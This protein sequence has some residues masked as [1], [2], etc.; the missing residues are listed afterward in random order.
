MRD[1]ERRIPVAVA[2]ICGR[3]GRETAA[4][5]LED[6]AF[7]LVLGLERPGHSMA[8]R[9]L[10][11]ESTE[12][13]GLRGRIK[14]VASESPDLSE[15]RVFV[16]FSTAEGSAHHAEMCASAGT[17]AVIGVT[18][19]SEEQMQT[20]KKASEKVA[21][22]YSPNMSTGV[23]L[24]AR[25]VAEAARR[26]PVAYDIE[27]VE[28]HHRGK[29][30]VPSGTAAMLARRAAEGRESKE[31]DIVVSRPAGLGR[32][33]GGEIA[34]HSIRGGDVPGDH[35]VR[36]IGSGETLAI[37]HR[38]HS[39]KAFAQGVPRAVRFVDSAGPGYYTMDDVLDA[40]E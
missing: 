35:E 38:A 6:P 25:L 24:V 3:M 26:L 40:G 33:Q 18:A 23:N 2:G 22:L 1:L 10:E 27:I 15:V 30:D 16:D 34:V 31:E 29:L 9:M 36:F 7:E 21:I 14:V 37:S 13:Q 11:I 28:A 32:R 17:A 5:I 20:L 39:R 8:G 19:L 12:G 4:V